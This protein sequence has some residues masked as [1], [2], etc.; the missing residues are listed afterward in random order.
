[1][2]RKFR[3]E[4]AGTLLA[5]YR[6]TRYDPARPEFRLVSVNGLQLAGFDGLPVEA[7][8]DRDWGLPGL[9]GVEVTVWV[10]DRM[11][12]VTVDPEVVV[13]YVVASTVRVPGDEDPAVVPAVPE[14][15]AAALTG[16]REEA[17]ID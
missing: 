7:V 16:A 3:T 6:A 2:Y 5:Q 1:M 12:S 13:G 10:G 9:F 15:A 14:V 17:D 11:T 8:Q 4:P